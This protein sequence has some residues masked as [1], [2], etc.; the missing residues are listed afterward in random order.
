V[1]LVS[2]SSGSRGGGELYLER[3]ATGLRGAGVDVTAVMSSDADMDLLAARLGAVSR[4]VRFRYR[5]TYKRSLR[6]LGAMLDAGAI[7]RAARLFRALDVDVIHVNKQNR[8]DGL[9]LLLAARQAQVPF[10]CTMHITRSARR[11]RA[12]FAAIRDHAA[13]LVWRSVECP[14][15]VAAEACKVELDGWLGSPGTADRTTVVHYGVETAPAG[16]RRGLVRQEWRVPPGS[17]V[18]GSVARLEPQ[19]EPFLTVRLLARLPAHFHLVWIGEGSML[20]A[21]RHMAVRLGVA[22]RL[23]LDGWRDDARARMAGFDIFLL[24]SRYEGLPMAV[25]DAMSAGLP[26]VSSGVDG[27]G[28]AVLDGVSGFLADVDRDDRWLAAIM[29]LADDVSLRRRFGWR[30]RQLCSQR[31]GASAMIEKTLTE[32]AAVLRK[33]G[34]AVLRRT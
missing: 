30:A 21:T 25:L 15:L 3:L 23:H 24:R 1:A 11:L 8:E 16:S 6:S 12:R 22:D 28:D 7:A 33:S 14:V 27:V 17:I 2:S 26:V 13:R 29:R 18:L 9:D 19:K 34:G 32:Y 10:L 4:V 5:N 31:F 20:S